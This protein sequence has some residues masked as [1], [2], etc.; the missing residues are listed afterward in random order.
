MSREGQGDSAASHDDISGGGRSVQECNFERGVCVVHK[1]KG[2]KT[3]TTAKKWAERK[4]GKG[5]EWVYSRQNLYVCPSVRQSR[6]IFV[7]NNTPYSDNS[8]DPG[9]YLINNRGENNP[10]G[11]SLS[12]SNLNGSYIRRIMF[13]RESQQQV[14]DDIRCDQSQNRQ[15]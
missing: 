6:N 8:R 5:F 1:L 7:S 2:R 3:V 10:A 14:K 13:E 11:D 9:A 4:K 15:L 12:I